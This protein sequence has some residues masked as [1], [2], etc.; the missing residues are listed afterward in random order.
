MLEFL[1]TFVQKFLSVVVDLL[2]GS[3][4]HYFI[5][6]IDLS[7]FNKAISWLN[8]FVPVGTLIAITEAWVTA[9]GLFY[10]YSIVLR[11]LKVIG[12]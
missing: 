12:D 11:W 6:S 7:N 4:F 9:I 3:P 10:V 5:D 8:W 2:P 1:Q